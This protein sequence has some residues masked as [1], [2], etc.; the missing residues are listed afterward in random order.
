MPA[1]PRCEAFCS[2]PTQRFRE[3]ARRRTGRPCGVTG[4]QR[5][6]RPPTAAVAAATAAQRTGGLARP[7]KYDNTTRCGV[8]NHRRAAEAAYTV[9]DGRPAN[10]EPP[11]QHARSFGVTL[12]RRS[13][14]RGQALYGPRRRSASRT[15]CHPPAAHRCRPAR[16][17]REISSV[18]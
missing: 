9:K 12:R 4:N 15:G 13:M 1:T 10:R 16:R 17:C 18:F 8:L 5:R 11:P 7:Y 2:R 6:V 3:R 14:R